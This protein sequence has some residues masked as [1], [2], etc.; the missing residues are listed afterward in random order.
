MTVGPLELLNFVKIK[1]P[2]ESLQTN[3]QAIMRSGLYF[4]VLK[5]FFLEQPYVQNYLF[6]EKYFPLHHHHRDEHEAL[7]ILVKFDVGL[8]SFNSVDCPH[9]NLTS[10]IYSYIAIY[11]IHMSY[12][13]YSYIAIYAIHMSYNIYSYIAIYST[14][15]QLL[16]Y[17]IPACAARADISETESGIIDLLV[18]KRPEKSDYK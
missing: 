12:N 2:F 15:I 7:M 16:E 1:N 5:K 17:P 8:L 4:L 9:H 10:H 6:F 3:P 18:S 14:R 13:I 11:S